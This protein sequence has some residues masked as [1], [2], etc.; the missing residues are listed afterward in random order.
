MTDKPSQPANQGR[1]TEKPQILTKGHQPKLAMDGYVPKFQGGH[2]PTT[3]QGAPSNPPNQ[4]SGGK[5][6]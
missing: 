2:Q 4:G 1:P 6:K 5:K 3:G